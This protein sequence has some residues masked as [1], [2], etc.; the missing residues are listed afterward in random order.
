MFSHQ[1]RRPLSPSSK[2]P[3]RQAFCSVDGTVCVPGW[4][5]LELRADL[6]DVHFSSKRK[7][8]SPGDAKGEEGE[9]EIPQAVPRGVSR[10]SLEGGETRARA[11]RG[12]RKEGGVWAGPGPQGTVGTVLPGLGDSGD[13]DGS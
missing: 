13:A 4:A 11:S 6:G 7:L 1:H 12:R 5:S 10:G 8:G 2:V 9:E 3:R